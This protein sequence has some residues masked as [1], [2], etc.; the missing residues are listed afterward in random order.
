[1]MTIPKKIGT[2][3]ADTMAAPK[4]GQ[5]RR[6]LAESSYAQLE[7]T[8]LPI[9]QEIGQP[10]K[11]VQDLLSAAFAAKSV[12]PKAVLLATPG[13]RQVVYTQLSGFLDLPKDEKW[14]MSLYFGQ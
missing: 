14:S 1:M 2:D 10:R 12:L 4:R 7:L 11:D 6:A 13:T 9:L 8:Y 5:L 3:G